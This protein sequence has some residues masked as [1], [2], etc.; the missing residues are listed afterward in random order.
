MCQLQM[1]RVLV[2]QRLNAAVEEIF[3]VFQRTIAQY[4]AELSRTKEE[5]HQLLDAVCKKHQLQDVRE[6]HLLPEQQEWTEQEEPQTLRIKEEEEEHSI[7]QEFPVTGVVVKSEDDEVKGESEEEPPR[8]ADGDH[9]GGPPTNKFVAPLSRSHSPDTD[10]AGQT[11]HTDNTHS[12]CSH[13]DKTFKYRSYLR[14]HMRTHTGEKPFMCSVCCKRFSLKENLK[15]HTRLHTGEK[16]FM[17][18]ICSKRFTRKAHLIFHTSIH[19]GVRPFSCS[20]CGKGYM[21]NADLT[22]HMR[23]HTGEK[24]FSCPNCNKSF[25]YRSALVR[26]MRRHTGEKASSCSL[27]GSPISTSVRNTCSKSTVKT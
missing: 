8:E 19:T 20:V 14:I 26:H 10:E 3:L 21:Q 17:C 12:K 4:E 15:K 24:P 2:N 7:S 13:C 16:P 18:L 5:N 6:E 9:C 22:V 25:C 23:K 27:K 11:R 1:L